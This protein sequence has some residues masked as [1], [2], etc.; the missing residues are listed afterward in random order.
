MTHCQIKNAGSILLPDAPVTGNVF[1]ALNAQS[2]SY[3][4]LIFQNNVVTGSAGYGA[5]IND[6][7]TPPCDPSNPDN[8]NFF[9]DNNLGE[10]YFIS[11]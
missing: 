7:V 2:S 5:I 10:Y 1:I 9:N 3:P 8:N 6:Y 11:K 4:F